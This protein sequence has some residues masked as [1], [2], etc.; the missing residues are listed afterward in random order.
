[1]KRLRDFRCD[2]CG[3][4]REELVEAETLQVEC[5]CGQMMDRQIG[6]P[7]IG[8][9]GIS[10][11]FPSAADRWANVREQKARIAQKKEAAG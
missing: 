3:S 11:A 7:R 1:M 9:E 10:G 4:E 2:R 6:M 5:S 8:L